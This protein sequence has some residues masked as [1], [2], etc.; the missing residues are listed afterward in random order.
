MKTPEEKRAYCREWRLKNREKYLARKRAL[1]HK[2]KDGWRDS[3]KERARKYYYEVLKPKMAKD[4]EIYR[5]LARSRSQKKQQIRKEHLK[6]LRL[7]LGGK[8]SH[9]PCNQLDI[10]QFH[11]YE[12]NKEAN[13]CEIQSYKKRELE[14]LKCIL[15]CPNCH[16]L[17]TLKDI[18]AK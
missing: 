10:L 7:K 13:V 6:E 15:L 3:A 8:C 4:P 2:N 17:E 18:R 9:C 16:A 14:A 1:Y 11:H 12:K 5:E